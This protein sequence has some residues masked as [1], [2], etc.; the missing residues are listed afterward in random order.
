M[1]RSLVATSASTMTNGND[2]R[3]SRLRS[4]CRAARASGSPGRWPAAA[5][6]AG[7]PV[8]PADARG[9]RAWVAAG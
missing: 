9:R 2:Q 1:V 5:T 6:T 3:A 4:R 8:R 7:Q